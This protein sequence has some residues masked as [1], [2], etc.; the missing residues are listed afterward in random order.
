M[1]KQIFAIIGSMLLSNKVFIS[2]SMSSP[3][4]YSSLL[5][6]YQELEPEFMSHVKFAG[7]M[8]PLNDSNVMKRFNRE[9][10]INTYWPR[11]TLLLIRRAIQYFPVIRPILKKHGI[12]DDFKYLPLIES[13]FRDM[14]SPA[15]AEGPWQFLARTGRAYGLTI[16]REVDERYDLTKA[17]EAACKYFKDSY[18]RLGNWTLVAAS[19]NMGI[20]GVANAANRQNADSYYD[21]DL[22]VQTSRYVFRLIAIKEIMERPRE[23]GFKYPNKPVY[24]ASPT[25]RIRVDTSVPNLVHFAKAHGVT[26]KTLR[27]MNPWIKSLSL[28]GKN[29]KTYYLYIPKV[30]RNISTDTTGVPSFETAKMLKNSEI[31]FLADNNRVETE[32]SGKK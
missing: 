21:L 13:G 22:N 6:Y 16:N 30:K 2:S 32:R 19:Y 31:S 29:S 25:I 23:Y 12:P 5:K 18:R 9:M 3:D 4:N 26:Y 20:S 10:H 27:A 1:K 14:V 11:Q 7:E 17:T 24:V 28:T 8:V 15:G